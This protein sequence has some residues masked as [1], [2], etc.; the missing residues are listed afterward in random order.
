MTKQHRVPLGH[1]VEYKPTGDW[2]RVTAQGLDNAERCSIYTVQLIDFNGK[3]LD[4]YVK[5]MNYEVRRL[6]EDVEYYE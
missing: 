5:A 1:L 2:G 4:T 6:R 3:L